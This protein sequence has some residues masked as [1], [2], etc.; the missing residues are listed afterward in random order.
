M[1]QHDTSGLK[2]TEKKYTDIYEQ[3]SDNF[4]YELL[5]NRYTII[6]Y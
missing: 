3:I 6:Y 2:I 5:S 1:M 4:D